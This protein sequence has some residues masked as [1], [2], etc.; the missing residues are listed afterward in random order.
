LL[1]DEATNSPT[2]ACHEWVVDAADATAEQ[3]ENRLMGHAIDQCRSSRSPQASSPTA[4][5]GRAVM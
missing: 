4:S 5:S 1:V 3:I 2:Q